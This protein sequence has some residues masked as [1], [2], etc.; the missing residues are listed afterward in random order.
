MNAVTPI[1]NLHWAIGHVPHIDSPTLDR[2][3]A[4]GASVAVHGWLY[5]SGTPGNG[6]PPFRTIVDSGIHVGAGADAAAVSVFDPWLEIYYMV[7]GKNAAGE[8]INAG[9]QLTRT[10]ALRL[11]KAEN[12]WFTREEDKMGTIEPGKFGDLVVL[13]GDFLDPKQVPDEAI[14]HLKSVLTVVGGRVV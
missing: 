9:Q 13:S 7:T 11:Y 14:K 2:P 12:G 8:L 6:R 5:L 1:A 3:K 4:I 10:E